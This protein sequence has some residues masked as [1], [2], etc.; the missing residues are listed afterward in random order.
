V[1]AREDFGEP[2]G[3]D[4]LLLIG[5]L[6]IDGIRALLSSVP[7]STAADALQVVLIEYRGKQE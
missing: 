2:L 7:P 4:I 6:L 1:S 5:E 3:S